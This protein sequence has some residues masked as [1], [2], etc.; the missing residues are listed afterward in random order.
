MKRFPFPLAVLLSVA[1]PAFG[2]D[3]VAAPTFTQV[4]SAGEV[5]AKGQLPRYHWR[6]RDATDKKGHRIKTLFVQPGKPLQLDFSDEWLSISNSCN[7]MSSD[8]MLEG[9]FLIEGD[10]GSQT[11][12]A[13][14]PRIQ[15][16]D[17]EIGKRIGRKMRY[18]FASGDKPVL[19]LFNADGDKL[20]FMGERLF[21]EVAPHE[22]PCAY[23][24]MRG[25]DCLQVREIRYDAKDRRIATA[26]KFEEFDASIAGYTHRDGVRD[27]LRIER[28]AIKDPPLGTSIYGYTL[29]AMI[30]SDAPGK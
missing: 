26:G 17:V 24:P 3:P 13:C 10:N 21:F 11:V 29:D 23:P 16:L 27:V 15:A 6:L 19:T 5:E 12:K 2:S 4:P 14:I 9:E 1:C 20:V 8:Y 28:F 25:K 30:E 18:A 22:K 7:S